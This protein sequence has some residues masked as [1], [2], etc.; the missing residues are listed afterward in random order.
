ME[1]NNQIS[2]LYKDCDAL[3]CQTLK[4]VE[5]AEE[6]LNAEQAETDQFR[7]SNSEM[8]DEVFQPTLKTLTDNLIS[9]DGLIKDLGDAGLQNQDHLHEREIRLSALRSRWENVKD[10]IIGRS[11][12]LDQFISRRDALDNIVKSAESRLQETLED[13]RISLPEKIEKL[14]TLSNDLEESMLQLGELIKVANSL[15]PLKWPAD[16]TEELR[17]WIKRIHQAAER[18]PDLQENTMR[19]E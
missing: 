1:L 18:D 11:L 5:E 3:Y 15:K 12:A 19:S 2:E 9:A 14:Q 6:L 10:P 16:S 7:R 13:T 17:D 8:V 4:N